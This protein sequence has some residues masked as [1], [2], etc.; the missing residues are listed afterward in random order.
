V[1]DRPA[2]AGRIETPPVRD[3]A[4]VETRPLLFPP[5]DDLQPAEVAERAPALENAQAAYD[6]AVKLLK[7]AAGTQKAYDE[8]EAALRSGQ[9]RLNSSQTKLTRRKAFS[10]VTGVVQQIYYR[11]GEIVAAGRPVVAI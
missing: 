9:A 2:A 4:R 10:P 7:S 3:A 5:D 6:R 11:V 1:V 8:A